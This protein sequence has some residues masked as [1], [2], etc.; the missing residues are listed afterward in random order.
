MS[1]KLLIINLLMFSCI[2]CLKHCGKKDLNARIYKGHDASWNRFPW[3]VVLDITF[4]DDPGNFGGG[5]LI[6]EKHI[7]TAAHILYK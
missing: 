1:L 7:L 3:H 2:H 5:V 4:S 6:S